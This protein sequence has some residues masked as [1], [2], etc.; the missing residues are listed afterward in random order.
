MLKEA[1]GFL[2]KKLYLFI[3]LSGP[4]GILEYSSKNAVDIWS[5]PGQ[6]SQGGHSVG[7]LH[8]WAEIM[9]AGLC[10]LC[11]RCTWVLAYPLTT[12]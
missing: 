2:K 6:E 5:L 9:V 10:Q 11:R 4:L 12:K 7:Q 3:Y 8:S 1:G